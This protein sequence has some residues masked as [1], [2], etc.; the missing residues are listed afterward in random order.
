MKKAKLIPEDEH[1]DMLVTACLTGDREGEDSLQAFVEDVLGGVISGDGCN[2]SFTYH[3]WAKVKQT[4]DG[5][6]KVKWDRVPKVSTVKDAAVELGHSLM[7]L[8]DHLQ[9]NKKIKMVIKEL[10]EEV[11]QPGSTSAMFHMDFAENLLAKVY[12]LLMEYSPQPNIYV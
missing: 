12:C 10:R 8:I 1:L 5:V 9:R 11:Q 2:K 7:V 3:K 4:V 6:E